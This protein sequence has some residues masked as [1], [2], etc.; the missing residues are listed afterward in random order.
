MDNDRSICPECQSL[1]QDCG[2]CHCCM[3]NDRDKRI[4]ELEGQLKVARK[5]DV[6]G[7]TDLVCGTAWIKERDAIKKHETEL[8]HKFEEL[9]RTINTLQNS[10]TIDSAIIEKQRVSIIELEAELNWWSN[11]VREKLN[12]K[13]GKQI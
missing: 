8:V 9:E 3:L 6:C 1:F 12:D 7:G 5:C 2:E 10:Q 11:L 4:E 13:D